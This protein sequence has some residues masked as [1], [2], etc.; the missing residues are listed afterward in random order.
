[1]AKLTIKDKNWLDNLDF[2]QLMDLRVDYAFKLLFATEIKLLISLLNAVFASAGIARTVVSLTLTNPY[3]EKKSQ[4]D[5]LSILDM[6][7]LPAG[8]PQN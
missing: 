7:R 4:D 2:S 5:K 1:M 6:T 8:R 3:L